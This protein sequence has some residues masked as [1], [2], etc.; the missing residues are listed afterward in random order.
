MCY[1]VSAFEH[2]VKLL[3]V[4]RSCKPILRDTP[5]RVMIDR[6]CGSNC[7][8]ASYRTEQSVCKLACR[9][10]H[11]HVTLYAYIGCE[12]NCDVAQHQIE[13]SACKLA[14]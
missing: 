10:V 6:C 14:R 3:H 12:S 8:D 5:C 7:N 13:Q 2:C 1:S 11:A 4:M 9:Y